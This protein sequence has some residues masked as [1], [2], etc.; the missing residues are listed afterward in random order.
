MIIVF[1]DIHIHN[2]SRFGSAEDRLNDHIKCLKLIL[3]A[4][5]NRDVDAVVFCGDMFEKHGTVSADVLVPVM[6]VFSDFENKRIPFVAISGNHDMTKKN[7]L[8][9]PSP[10]LLQVLNES[11]EYFKLIDNDF[12]D[13]R[14]YRFTG[15]PYLSSKE[16]ISRALDNVELHPDKENIL[17]MH[18]TPETDNVMIDVDID[19]YDERIQQFDQVFNGHIH[20]R[21]SEGKFHVIGNPMQRTLNDVGVEKGVYFYADGKMRFVSMNKHLP[22]I[23][24]TSDPK[25]EPEEGVIKIV[26][27]PEMEEVDAEIVFEDYDQL[28]EDYLEVADTELDKGK[29]LGVI[30]SYL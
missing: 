21:F 5:V 24:I 15:I 11:F 6:E 29:L 19:M 2:S 25:S 22:E 8:D 16:D 3:R 14:R 4:A 7:Y 27:P 9:K 17:L 13:H 23:K 26:K 18:N 30:K 10:T 1:S 28:L 12:F 20:D